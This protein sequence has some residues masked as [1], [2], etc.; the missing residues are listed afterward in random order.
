MKFLEEIAS[1]ETIMNCDKD[2]KN[3]IINF[4]PGKILPK[5]N[6]QWYEKETYIYLKKGFES[7]KLINKYNKLNDE[8]EEIKKTFQSVGCLEK[9]HNAINER[10]ID[11]IQAVYIE[12]DNLMKVAP[13]VLELKD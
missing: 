12:I 3:N 1:I 11:D 4:L 10:S 2:F 8:M 13:Q 7:L 9:L 5:G 6:L